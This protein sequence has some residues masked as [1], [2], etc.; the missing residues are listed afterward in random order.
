MNQGGFCPTDLSATSVFHTGLCTTGAVLAIIAPLLTCLI[1][2]TD[3]QLLQIA[4]VDFG[5]EIRGMQICMSCDTPAIP[6]SQCSCNSSVVQSRAEG[7]QRWRH[8]DVSCRRMC[9]TDTGVCGVCFAYQASAE[10]FDRTSTQSLSGLQAATQAIAV[11]AV[12]VTLYAL[13]WCYTQWLLCQSRRWSIIC[14]IVACVE[15]AS[16]LSFAIVPISAASDL[17]D[18]FHLIFVRSWVF[19]GVLWSVLFVAAGIGGAV[20]GTARC[21]LRLVEYLVLV[22]LVLVTILCGGVVWQDHVS[23]TWAYRVLEA[24]MLVSA[25]SC[26]LPL[27]YLAH[28]PKVAEDG[29][30]PRPPLAGGKCRYTPVHLVPLVATPS[31]QRR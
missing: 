9:D 30:V 16:V 28:A 5:V 20:A 13:E 3:T 21:P 2:Y 18:A 4:D 31:V 7:V 23:R 19:S 10:C 24:S 6:T 12:G 22:R 26:S 1:G 25:V 29:C 11:F 17:L 15:C 8:T 27:V 14:K